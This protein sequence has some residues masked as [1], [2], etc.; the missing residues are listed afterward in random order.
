MTISGFNSSGVTCAR[1][2][3]G[4][5]SYTAGR[6]A[7][8]AYWVSGRE[9]TCQ[10]PS[11]VGYN[12]A[13]AV[14]TVTIASTQTAAIMSPAMGAWWR[15]DGYVGYGNHQLFRRHG[16]RHRMLRPVTRSGY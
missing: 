16:Y 5:V 9:A 1:G 11:T 10:L 14:G 8:T 15:I 12:F 2:Y 6:S 7:G 4:S 13:G 3:P